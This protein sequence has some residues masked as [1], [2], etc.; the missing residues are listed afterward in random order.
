MNT[1]VV[2]MGLEGRGWIDEGEKAGRPFLVF[3][4]PQLG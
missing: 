1:R 2:P 4:P 3:L